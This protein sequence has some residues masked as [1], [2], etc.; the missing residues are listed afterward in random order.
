MKFQNKKK[1]IIIGAIPP[2][3]N[4]MTIL[5]QQ[6]LNSDLNHKFQIR[7]LDTSYPSGFPNMGKF[8]IGTVFRTIR[9]IIFLESLLSEFAPQIVYMA[10]S[11]KPLGL[12]RDMIMVYISHWKGAR[13]II[14]LHNNDKVFQEAKP[15]VRCMLKNIC[16]YISYAV[17]VH[18]VYKT[19]FNPFLRAE[20]VIAIPNGISDIAKIDWKNKNEIPE[21]SN[22]RILF[23]S[24]LQL[25]KG[26]LDLIH[27]IPLIRSRY[28]R[29]M[30]TFAGAVLE[31]LAVQEAK[32]FL[33]SNNLVDAVDWQGAVVGEAKI[34]LFQQSD[35]FVFP[36]YYHAES[37]GLVILEAMAMGL[38]IVATDHM[39]IPEIAVHGVNGIIVP[40][41]D[42][43]SLANA[44]ISLL[45]DEGLRERIGRV[46][47]AE[48]LEKYTE[49]IFIQRISDIFDKV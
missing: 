17:V 9:Q 25:E 22:T 5:T 47:R 31:P 36:T 38:P 46:N 10:I 34:N 23:L 8:N 21:S 15:F 27:A 11:Y 16:H 18:D 29:V 44:V 39:A 41:Q 49:T 2:P 28:D 33:Q 24:N 37:F 12:L 48:Y 6:I 3:A 13:I 30:F 7:H 35:V 42:P 40:K 26:F 32:E 1:V 20:K 19:A 43:I 45:E 14:H 4:G